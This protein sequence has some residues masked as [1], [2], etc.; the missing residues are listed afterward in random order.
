MAINQDPRDPPVGDDPSRPRTADLDAATTDG[1]ATPSE[2]AGLHTGAGPRNQELEA[3]KDRNLRLQA[4]L[5]N[6]ADRLNLI[7][8]AG[9]FSG[10]AIGAPRTGALRLRFEF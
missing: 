2:S 3:E 10:T 6:L 7:N 1:S 8:F 5:F 9:L 4:D